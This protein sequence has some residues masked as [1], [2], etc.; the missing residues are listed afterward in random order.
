MLIGKHHLRVLSFEDTEA[1]VKRNDVSNYDTYISICKNEMEINE[2]IDVTHNTNV[3]KQDLVPVKRKHYN[4]NYLYGDNISC[5]FFFF[6]HRE[7]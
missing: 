2:L 5:F 6:E 4:N 1:I 3:K 7:L